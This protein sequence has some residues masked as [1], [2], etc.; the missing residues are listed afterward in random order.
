M[1]TLTKQIQQYPKLIGAVLIIL[2]T[3]GLWGL[4]NPDWKPLF[5]ALTPVNLLL[6]TMLFLLFHT[7]YKSQHITAFL[8]VYLL[9]YIIEMIGVNTGM[10]FGN[11]TYQTALGIKVLNT[12]LLIGINW[13]MLSYGFYTIFRK[14]IQKPWLRVTLSALGMVVLDFFIEPVA[15]LIQMWE[16]VDHVPPAQNFVAWFIVSVACMLLYERFLKDYKNDLAPWLIGT[17]FMFFI[18]LN[19]LA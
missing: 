15:P 6:T 16:W 11:Y 18:G 7:P 10:L 4:N 9:G 13:V 12:P 8:S 19:L 14:I 5:L 2:H 17:Q 3:V 1:K